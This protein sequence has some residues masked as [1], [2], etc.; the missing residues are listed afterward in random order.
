M[1]TPRQIRQF[2]LECLRWADEAENASQRDV[3]IRIARKWLATASAL[4]SGTQAIETTLP[5]L[6]PK[7]D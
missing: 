3:I 1:V 4:E 7:L 5:N 6:R 2:A